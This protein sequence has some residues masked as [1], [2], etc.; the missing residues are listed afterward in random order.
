MSDIQAH[1]LALLARDVDRLA[2]FYRDVL[3]L[4]AIEAPR[5]GVAWF[6]LGTTLLMIEPGDPSEPSNA[7][8]GAGFHL[9]ALTMSPDQRADWQERLAAHGVA[10]THHTDYSLYFRD[11]EGNRLALSHYPARD[12]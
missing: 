8:P 11:P 9:L 3:G 4:E 1:H 12:R 7:A 10:I 6:R 5:P 2:R